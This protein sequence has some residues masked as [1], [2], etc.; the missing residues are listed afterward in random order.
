MNSFIRYGDL[1]VINHN[2]KIAKV[3][4]NE[5]SEQQQA[6]VNKNPELYGFISAT[7]YIIFFNNKISSYLDKNIYFQTTKQPENGLQQSTAQ[8]KNIINYRDFVWR[9]YPK[10]N[11]EFHKDY[12]KAIQQYKSFIRRKNYSNKSN[13]NS[14][15]SEYLEY[16]FLLLF[17]N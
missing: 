9:I 1:I 3:N 8:Q 15:R 2:G 16:T 14:D 12:Q 4:R 10:L 11:F 17:Y 7:G 13:G 6:L 5:E